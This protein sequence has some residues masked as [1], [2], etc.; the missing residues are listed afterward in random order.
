M[1]EMV[2]NDECA[3]GG[4]EPGHRLEYAYTPASTSQ[5]RSG[6]QTCSGAPDDYD[7]ATVMAAPGPLFHFSHDFFLS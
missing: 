6:I 2:R 5:S 4:I 3:A 1:S 7:L